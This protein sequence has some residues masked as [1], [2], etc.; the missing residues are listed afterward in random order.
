MKTGIFFLILFVAMTLNNTALV[1][2][3]PTIQTVLGLLASIGGC[4]LS[5]LL[6]KSN[7]SDWRY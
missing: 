3:D 4:V 1:K 5:W 7:D 6:I 2:A